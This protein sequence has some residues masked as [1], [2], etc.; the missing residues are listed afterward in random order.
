MQPRPAHQSDKNKTPG[1]DCRQMLAAIRAG[2]RLWPS[3]MD[4]GAGDSGAGYGAGIGRSAGSGRVGPPRQRRCLCLMNLRGLVEPGL[5]VGWFTACQQ[6][7]AENN[8]DTLKYAQ[9]GSFPKCG[10]WPR[11]RKVCDEA[12]MAISRSVFRGQCLRVAPLRVLRQSETDGKR[13]GCHTLTT[14]RKG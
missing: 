8:T 4:A 3:M 10:F 9:R 13:S 1:P 7:A 2:F 5:R 14:A 12:E 6:Q 11:G